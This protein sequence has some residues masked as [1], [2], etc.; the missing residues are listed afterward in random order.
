M[1]QHQH[2][3]ELV[4]QCH[5]N[6]IEELWTFTKSKLWNSQHKLYGYGAEGGGARGIDT[7]TNP[8]HAK[9]ERRRGDELI[10]IAWMKW[11]EIIH[12]VVDTWATHDKHEIE[13]SALLVLVHLDYLAFHFPQRNTLLL[14]LNTCAKKHARVFIQ[15]NKKIYLNREVIY[16]FLETMVTLKSSVSASKEVSLLQ[17]K[18][19]GTRDGLLIYYLYHW[20]D[21]IC[22]AP[23]LVN[24]QIKPM[25]YK[26]LIHRDVA[27]LSP[28]VANQNLLNQLLQLYQL[29]V[30]HNALVWIYVSAKNSNYDNTTDSQTPDNTK[31]NADTNKEGNNTSLAFIKKLIDA[32]LEHYPRLVTHSALYSIIFETLISIRM[33][34]SSS[35][36]RASM[37]DPKAKS[38]HG[39]DVFSAKDDFVNIFTECSIFMME[40][41]CS[42]YN[43]LD[44]PY[45]TSSLSYCGQMIEMVANSEDSTIS[46]RMLKL[47]LSKYVVAISNCDDIVKKKRISEW[48][49]DTCSRIILIWHLCYKLDNHT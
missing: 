33:N 28:N 15:Q 49:F 21:H 44:W 48:Y 34:I 36:K 38:I 8:H 41:I 35:S 40:M 6:W 1:G 25:L 19:E 13:Q 30:R 42:N 3:K 12:F 11:V 46:K 20:I 43:I 9:S 37:V 26:Y 18:M 5:L 24:T 17:Q 2:K 7:E 47:I 23:Y 39:N 45:I 27:K 16:P 29:T 32:S 10:I 14:L 4:Y 22:R 31:S